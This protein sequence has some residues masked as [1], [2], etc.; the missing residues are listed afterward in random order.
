MRSVVQVYLGPPREAFCRF[1][2]SSLQGA[3]AQLGERRFCKAEV[4]GSI[5]IS[6]T[7]R[8]FEIQNSLGRRFALTVVKDA[9]TFTNL[10]VRSFLRHF[11]AD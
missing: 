1:D 7:S 2:D 6:S 11:D 10:S 3:V 8:S 9:G 4:V 5:P